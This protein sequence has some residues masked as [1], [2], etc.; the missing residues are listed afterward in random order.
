[1]K[2]IGGDAFSDTAIESISIPASVTSIGDG[3]FSSCSHLETVIC[4]AENALALGTKNFGSNTA[5]TLWVPAGCKENYMGTAWETAF[6]T[7]REIG[8]SDYP[9]IE[10]LNH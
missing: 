7:I 1:L 6:K 3:A 4:L 5:D 2:S 10:D 9:V 8:V